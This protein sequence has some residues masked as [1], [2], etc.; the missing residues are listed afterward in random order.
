MFLVLIQY[1]SYSNIFPQSQQERNGRLRLDSKSCASFIFS[2]FVSAL[3]GVVPC[4]VSSSIPS[5]GH[6]RSVL[7]DMNALA[8][9]VADCVLHMSEDA[10]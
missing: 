8:G 2:A 4:I 9:V 6:S 7:D 3:C 5:P 1:N 10:S